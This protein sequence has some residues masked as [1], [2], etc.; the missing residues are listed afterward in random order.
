MRPSPSSPELYS[1]RNMLQLCL[2]PNNPH[3]ADYR[4][5]GI[6]VTERWRGRGA[7]KRFIADMGSRPE[8][9]SLGRIDN[10]GNYS[11]ENCRWATPEEQGASRRE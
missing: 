10:D 9:T 6:T 3:Y 5:R 7:E 4:E 11:A 2:N 1:Y 8:G